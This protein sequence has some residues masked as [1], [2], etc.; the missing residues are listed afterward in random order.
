[1]ININKLYQNNP[2]S[3]SLKEKNF[4]FKK[5]FNKLTLYHYKKSKN[6]KKILKYFNYNPKK[7]IEINKIPFIP[8]RL[9]KEFD[10]ISTNK[11]N[12]IKTLL[13]S[14]TTGDK[15]S[16]IFLDKNN[17]SNQVKALQKIMTTILG[18]E[19]LP[20]LIIDKNFKNLDRTQFNARVAAINGFSIFGKDHTF[21]LNSEGEI[22]YRILNN[23]LKKYSKNKFLIFGFTSFVFESLINKLSKK[24]IFSNFRNGILVH[25]GGW[26]KLENLKVSNKDFK[27]KLSKKINLNNIHNYYGLVEQTGS[28]FLECKCGYFVTSNFS[29]VLIRDINFKIAK[30]NQKGFLQLFS[31]LPTS[32]PGHNILTEDIAEIIDDNKCKCSLNGKKFLVHRR[33]EKAEIRGCSD[34]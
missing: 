7:I 22:N 2:Y 19:R 12:I 17:A 31:L 33:I 30:N 10:M 3:M 32:Y 24:L 9:F 27:K 1:M 16:K 5:N 13:S 28:I 25:G 20:M 14:G 21:I 23:F 26:K 8:I 34:T 6:Y 29:D 15:R 11:K 4:F 18:T